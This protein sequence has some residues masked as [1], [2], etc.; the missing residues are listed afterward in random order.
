MRA[1][2]A[3]KRA[4][5]EPTLKQ[6][7]AWIAVWETER[8]VA[9]ALEWQRTGVRTGANGAAWDTCFELL[10]GDVLESF[11]ASPARVAD[12]ELLGKIQKLLATRI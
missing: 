12:L 7:L 3:V 6:A 9:Q 5:Q 2:E 11:P 4:C 8:V 10:F 1:N